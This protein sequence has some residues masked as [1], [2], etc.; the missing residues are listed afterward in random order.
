MGTDRRARK[1]E[2]IRALAEFLAGT[3]QVRMSL[4][5]SMPR[6][7][8]HAVA[9]LWRDVRQATPLFGYPSVEEAEAELREFLG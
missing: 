1:A 9:E 6:S 3:N 7:E 5:L 4:A 2:F 8:L